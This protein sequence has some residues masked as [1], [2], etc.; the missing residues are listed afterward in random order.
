MSGRVES[1]IKMKLIF[2]ELNN[3]FQNETDIR[4][5]YKLH[6][7]SHRFYCSWLDKIKENDLINVHIGN[8]IGQIGIYIHSLAFITFTR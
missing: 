8:A 5:W 3:V 1:A 2:S 7:V 6:I 4:G